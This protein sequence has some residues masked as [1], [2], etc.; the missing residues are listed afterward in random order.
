M[1]ED[2]III[3]GGPA[4]LTAA[5]YTSREDF[6]P[7]VVAGFKAGGQLLL[8]TTVENYPAFPDGVD[9]TELVNLMR[10]QAERFGARFVDEDVVEVDLNTKPFR[11]KTS[12]Q[13]Y[14]AKCVILAPGASNRWL[15]IPSE[16]K[17]MG[18]GVS[19]CATCDGPFFKNKDVVVVGGGD[20]AMEDSL[21]LT[22]LAKSVTIIHRRNEFRASKIMQERVLNNP[23]IKVVWDSAV[24]EI[25]G[26]EKVTGVRVKS[27][28]T[29]ET[30]TIPANG[31]FIAIGYIPNTKFLEGK[32]DLDE[33][34]YIEAIDE[35][36][37]GIDGVFVAGD[38]ADRVYRQAVTAA[39]SGCKAAIAAREYIQNLGF[40][41]NKRGMALL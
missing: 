41:K 40:D 1:T 27:L 7:L 39:G 32:L 11:I 2:I 5:I 20:T 17:F 12:S 31:V 6:H 15:G 24:E 14:E 9:G 18:K 13:Q 33:Q 21:F 25:L 38:V 22:K 8:T 28:K 30:A 36:H 37:T 19:S 34:G 35:I 29:N 3:G 10:K 26:D 4:G 23:K 16:Q